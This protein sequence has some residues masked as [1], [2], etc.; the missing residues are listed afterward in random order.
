MT[1]GWLRAAAGAALGLLARAWLATLRVRVEEHPAFAALARRSPERPWVLAFFHGTQFPL[2]AWRRRRETVVMVSLSNDGALQ[3]RAL[4]RLG[5][6]VVRG[7]SSRGGAR[8]LAAVVRAMRGRGARAPAFARDAA[9][10]VDGPR[11]PYGE[12]KPGAALAARRAGGV[13]VPM[14]SAVARGTIFARA[15]DR[16][17]LPWPFSRVAV[18]LGAPI[19]PDAADP[20]ALASALAGAIAGANARAGAILRPASSQGDN[21]PTVCRA[22][23]PRTRR[24]D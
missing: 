8:G 19:E 13:L 9:F 1:A 18:V 3:A 22:S 20:A 24:F 23:S 7:S 6:C 11:G 14:G 4:A 2:L 17:A 10:A 5:F 21:L 12:P 16:F 15:W